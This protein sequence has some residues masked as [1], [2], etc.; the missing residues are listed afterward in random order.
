MLLASVAKPMQLACLR[1]SFDERKILTNVRL[2]SLFDS[3]NMDFFVQSW[4]L[5]IKIL[6][7]RRITDSIGLLPDIDT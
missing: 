1:L 6:D 5:Y 7:I 4:A 2:D 3:Q